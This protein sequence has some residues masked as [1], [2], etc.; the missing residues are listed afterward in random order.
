MRSGVGAL[1]GAMLMLALAWLPGPAWAFESYVAV[2]RALYE[3]VFAEHRKTLYCGCP[4]DAERRPDLQACGYVSK[5]GARAN[6]VEVEHVVPAS[7][8][9]QGRPC[10]RKKICR[11]ARGKAFKG[12]K[13]CLAVDPAFRSA[14]QD[15]HNLW[16]TI[17]EVNEVRRNYRFGLIA[18]ERRAFGRCDIEIDRSA[19]LAEPRPEIRGD[20]ARIHLYMEATHGIGV[21]ATLRRLLH[22]WHRDDP[23]DA[24]E[25]RR[26]DLI[27]GVQG[28]RNPWVDMPATM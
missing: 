3:R 27:E 18:G 15:M 24:E 20:I 16:P 22:R 13:C 17:G 7:W 21:D 10:W 28:R 9:G 5:G 4:F 14:S 25:R 26:H 6:R 8:L 19:R 11:D 1:T 23:P 12:R 2:K